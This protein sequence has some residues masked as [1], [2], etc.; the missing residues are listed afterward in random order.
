MVRLGLMAMATEAAEE[1]AATRRS[2]LKS[3]SPGKIYCAACVAM[4]GHRRP[5]QCSA[6]AASRNSNRDKTFGE[7]SALKNRFK[8]TAQNVTGDG[9]RRNGNFALNDAMTEGELL[10]ITSF[11]AMTCF[12]K[13]DT[14]RVPA[15]MMLWTNGDD[16]GYVRGDTAVT[17]LRLKTSRTMGD[18]DPCI[19]ALTSPE[20]PRRR[21]RACIP[22]TRAGPPR[23]RASID[24]CKLGRLMET[25]INYIDWGGDM[26]QC[27]EVANGDLATQEAVYITI[28]IATTCCEVADPM[29]TPAMTMLMTNGEGNGYVRGG[30]AATVSRLKMP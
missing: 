11:I 9:K 5:K 2:P 23:P 8:A 10:T 30:T 16:N 28:Y 3:L 22:V 26:T 14:T 25:T 15:M 19:L 6:A 17:I 29:M 24:R 4:L 1:E 13:V 21:R 20:P 27:S 12:K 18:S 7:V